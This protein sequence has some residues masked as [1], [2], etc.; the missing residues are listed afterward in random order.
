MIVLKE[1]HCRKRSE[2]KKFVNELINN[3]KLFINVKLDVGVHYDE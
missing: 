2:S 3:Y 1:S